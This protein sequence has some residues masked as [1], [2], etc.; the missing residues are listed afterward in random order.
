MKQSSL[1]LFPEIETSDI[2][3]KEPTN[4]HIRS[5]NI[6]TVLYNMSPN[7]YSVVDDITAADMMEFNKKKMYDNRITKIIFFALL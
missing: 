5:K 7:S 3:N 6:F 2:H 1:I 4:K